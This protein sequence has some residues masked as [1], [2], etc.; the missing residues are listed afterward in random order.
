MNES[1]EARKRRENPVIN[2]NRDRQK[3]LKS[4]SRKDGKKK[5]K[6]KNKRIDLRVFDGMS[7]NEAL[8]AVKE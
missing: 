6:G 1:A 4:M 2:K 5:V 7:V 3:R 8:E